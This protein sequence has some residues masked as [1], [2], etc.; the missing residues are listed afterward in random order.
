VTLEVF[1]EEKRLFTKV[2]GILNAPGHPAGVYYFAKIEYD[3]N[4]IIKRSDLRE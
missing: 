1:P 4:I 3:K 2:L